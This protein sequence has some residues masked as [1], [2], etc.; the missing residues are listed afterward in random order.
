MLNLKIGGKGI[1]IMAHTCNPS[2]QKQDQENC[3][4]EAS[5]GHIARLCFKK[6]NK[7]K[8]LFW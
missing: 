7:K 3:K 5:L 6:T 8:L 1:G 2:T 4:L